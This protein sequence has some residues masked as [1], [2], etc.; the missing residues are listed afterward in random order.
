MGSYPEICRIP[1]APRSK[2]PLVVRWQTLPA[3]DENFQFSAGDNIGIRLDELVVVDCDSASAVVWWREQG[4]PTDFVSRGQEERRSFWYRLPPLAALRPGKLRP[5]VDLKLGPGH[6][7]VVPPSIHP[8]GR[9]Y[10]WLG[11]PV[12]EEHWWEVPEAP[13]DLLTSIRPIAPVLG[14][15]AG[16]VICDGEGRDV[17]L[18]SVGG[19]LRRRGFGYD[20]IHPFLAAGNQAVCEPPLPAA[21]VER[22]ARSVCR[23]QPKNF[24]FDASTVIERT[25]RELDGLL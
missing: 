6:F 14:N 21:D 18:T 9:A 13:V 17:T 20:I 23:Y 7:M 10:E 15:G 8:T 2:V 4:F 5:D 24:Q 3:H 22:I 19:T 11:L 16:A 1:L 12:D 25:V